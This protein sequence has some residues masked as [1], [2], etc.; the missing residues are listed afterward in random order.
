M[1]WTEIKPPTEGISFY[2]HIDCETPLGVIRIEWKSWKERPDYGIDLDGK[3][4]GTEYDLDTAKSVAKEYLIT[5]Y[6]ELSKLLGP[7]TSE[8]KYSDGLVR[9]YKQEEED[10]ESFVAFSKTLI[11]K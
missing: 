1:N 9:I 2:Y 8:S 6:H 7:S 11:S 5:K 4:I 3:Y 10:I